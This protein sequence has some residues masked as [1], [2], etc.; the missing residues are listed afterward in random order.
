MIAREEYL[1]CRCRHTLQLEIYF[2]RDSPGVNLVDAAFGHSNDKPAD[3][4]SRQQEVVT[5]RR[6]ADADNE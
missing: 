2:P 6:R 4:I 1:N 3:V 5:S